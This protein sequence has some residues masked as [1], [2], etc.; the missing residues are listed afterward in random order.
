MLDSWSG[1]LEISQTKN[2]KSKKHFQKWFCR[3]QDRKLYLTTTKTVIDLSKRVVGWS[4]LSNSTFA[5]VCEGSNGLVCRF[6]NCSIEDRQAF[7]DI[8]YSWYCPLCMLLESYAQKRSYNLKVWKRRFCILLSSGHLIIFNNE[9]LSSVR[10]FVFVD[11]LCYLEAET[12]GF[13]QNCLKIED[14]QLTSHAKA[15][16]LVLELPEIEEDMSKEEYERELVHWHQQWVNS[17]FRVQQLRSDMNFVD[18]AIDSNPDALIRLCMNR[19]EKL[20]SSQTG[21]RSSWRQMKHDTLFNGELIATVGLCAMSNKVRAEAWMYFSGAAK[22]KALSP[23]LHYVSLLRDYNSRKRILPTRSLKTISV[24]LPRLRVKDEKKLASMK[25]VLIAMALQNPT[26]GY[27]QSFSY[28]VSTLLEVLSEVDAF[29]VLVALSEDH[30]PGYFS[31]EFFGVSIDLLV[32]DEMLSCHFPEIDQFFKEK[33]FQFIPVAYG[34]MNMLH[35]QLP[36][37]TRIRLWDV[38]FMSNSLMLIK[39]CFAILLMAVDKFDLLNQDDAGFIYMSFD[40][41]MSGVFNHPGVLLSMIIQVM[42]FIELHFLCANIGWHSKIDEEFNEKERLSN[43]KN[44]VYKSIFSV[45]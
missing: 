17:V 29:W 3:L 2:G 42:L 39:A 43:K 32:M 27:V 45:I 40:Q 14:S 5:I 22:R 10:R 16:F 34:W 12:S 38:M 25:R 28:I 18:K 1:W 24:D 8:L 35:C 30:L 37:E 13:S 26:V 36:M 31:H 15:E 19:N 23:N 4:I 9:S 21:N 44:D 11:K 41:V 6:D 20:I 7:E 33:M